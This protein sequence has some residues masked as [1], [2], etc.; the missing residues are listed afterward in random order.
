MP[1]LAVTG[2]D[3]ALPYNVSS[4]FESK[5]YYPNAC[6]EMARS[7]R[8]STKGVTKVESD[9]SKII[10]AI[11]FYSRLYKAMDLALGKRELVFIHSQSKSAC[12]IH[13]EDAVKLVNT[14]VLFEPNNR[15]FYSCYTSV[16]HFREQVMRAEISLWYRDK[17]TFCSARLQRVVKAMYP[18]DVGF[19]RWEFK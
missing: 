13:P 17:E 16:K 8:V 19:V 14:L 4:L 9:T 7:L 12:E 15:L 3:G 6:F 1:H 10:W 5:K 11:D 2:S 18:K